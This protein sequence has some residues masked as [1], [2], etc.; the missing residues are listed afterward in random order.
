M[1]TPNGPFSHAHFRR[2][3]YVLPLSTATAQRNGEVRQG[4]QAVGTTAAEGAEGGGAPVRLGRTGTPGGVGEGARQ[5]RAAGAPR[6]KE[7]G[8]S[9]QEDEARRK[10][11]E[12]GQEARYPRQL[13]L[14][15]LESRSLE[16]F[17][18]CVE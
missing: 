13:P 1:T 11:K 15:F 18:R 7:S 14:R 4:R 2:V 10:E 16:V 8:Q 17:G 5:S 9:R 12:E 6:R 3:A